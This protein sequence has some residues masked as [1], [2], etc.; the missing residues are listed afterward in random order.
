MLLVLITS[1]VLQTITHA[2]WQAHLAWIWVTIPLS[3][4]DTTDLDDDGNTAESIP[5]DLDGN[6]THH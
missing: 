5:F 4:P 6:P 2:C 1:S 3:P